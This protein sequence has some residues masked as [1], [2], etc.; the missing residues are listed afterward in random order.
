MQNIAIVDAA[1]QVMLCDLIAQVKFAHLESILMPWRH[2]D[3][4]HIGTI[5][6]NY[7]FSHAAE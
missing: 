1:P 6:A 4:D 7:E 3:L 2:K 5:V